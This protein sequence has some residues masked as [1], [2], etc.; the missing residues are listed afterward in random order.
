[1][2][3]DDL[4]SELLKLSVEDREF[5]VHEIWASI[6]RD[7]GYDEIDE[8]KTHGLHSVK[9]PEAEYLNNPMYTF[10][11]GVSEKLR[12]PDEI[13]QEIKDL[14]DARMAA[15]ENGTEKFYDWQEL[16]LKYDKLVKR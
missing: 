8:E 3:I 10:W 7:M 1:M 13:S 15:V 12:E 16:K 2:T 14:L 9:E 6:G 11:K 5:L 4:F